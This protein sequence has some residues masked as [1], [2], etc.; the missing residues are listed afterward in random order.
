MRK[1]ERWGWFTIYELEKGI[2]TQHTYTLLDRQLND[3]I[4]DR[5]V[6]A[7]ELLEGLDKKL[8]G[9]T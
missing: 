6:P 9:L 8:R 4:W 5:H 2:E 7:H 1:W 3:G